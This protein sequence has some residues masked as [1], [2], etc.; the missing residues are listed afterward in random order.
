MNDPVL[1]SGKLPTALLSRLL[2]P[3]NRDAPELLLPPSVGEDAGVIDIGG[4]ALVVAT[5]PI[6]L[7]GREIGG[8][9]VL[10]NANDVAVLGV[11]PRWFLAVFLLPVGT[12]ESEVSGMFESMREA[13]EKLDIVL[14][15][16]HTEVTP[17]VVQPVVTGQMLGFQKEGHF[18]KTGGVEVGDAIVQIGSAPIEGAAVLAH[19]LADK[20]IDIPADTL[21]MARDTIRDPGISV[22]D[23]ALRAATL[24]ATAMHDPTE[25]GLSAGLHEMAEASQVAL[26]VD[27]DAVLWFA[28]GIALCEALHADPW[29]ML[30]S[31]T[32]LTAFPA[33]VT[34]SALAALCADGYEAAIIARA[35]PGF[36]VSLVNGEP[37]PRYEQDEMSRLLAI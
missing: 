7:T 3:F 9:A 6:T 37:L 8:H 26:Q 24:G 36:G 22:V 20:L 19:E 15:G 5:D 17:A 11:R 29:G 35:V 23:P 13:L 18:L 14:V 25:G 21:R 4:G 33:G 27:G 10:I 32:V 30:A 2:A 16:G 31:G 28:P 34:D 12:T 1:P